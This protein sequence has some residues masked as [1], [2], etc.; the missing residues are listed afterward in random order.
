VIN[1]R[2]PL[3]D[4]KAEAHGDRL[5]NGRRRLLGRVHRPAQEVKVTEAT[6]LQ[7]ELPPRGKLGTQG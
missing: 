1:P 7:H 3:V 4:E 5:G 6:F 2:I